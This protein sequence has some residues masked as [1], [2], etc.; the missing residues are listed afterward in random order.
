MPHLVRF[1]LFLLLSFPAT[2]SIAQVKYYQ[3]DASIKVIAY[4]QEQPLAWCGGFNT[5]QFASADLDHDGLND[6]VVF[7]KGL[8]VTTFINRGTAGKPDYVFAPEYAV[9]F[10]PIKN[11]LVLADYNCDG[12]ADLFQWGGYGFAVYKGYYNAYNQLCFTFVK[13]LYYFND[14]YAGGPVNAYCNPG[15]IPAIVDVDGDGDLDFISYDI[16]GGVMN[17]YKNMRE[18]LHLPCD[19]LHIALKDRCWGRVYQGFERAHRLAYSCDNSGLGRETKVTHSG[20]TPCLFDWDMDGDFDYLDGSVSFNEMTFLKNG[21]TEHGGVDSM[22][23]QDS[24]WQTGGKQINIPIWPAAY[25]I[26]V[27]QDGKKDLLIAPNAANSSEN[28]KC[29]WYYK[30]LSTPGNPS[31][32]FQSDSFLID[33]TIDLGSASYPM[34]FDYNRDSLPDLFV[35]SDGYRQSSGLLQSRISYYLNTGSPGYPKFTLQTND[36]LGMGSYA[37]RG[38]AP[39]VGDIDNDGKADLIIGHT[40]G[41]LSYFKNAATSNNLQPVWKL[42]QLQ[43]VDV[44]NDTINAGGNAAPFI[45]DIDKDGKPD[46][47]IG[48]SYG[49]IR[50]YQ[51]ISAVRGTISLKLINKRLGNT[52]V[53]PTQNL[54]NYCTPFIGRIDSTGVDYL[55]LG[56]NSGNIYRYTGFQGGDTTATYTLL[57][58]QY[59]YI[60]TTYLRINHPNTS[61][62]VYGNRRSALTVGD[63]GKDGGFEMIVGNVKGGLE[64]YKWKDPSVNPVLPPQPVK[65]VL[66]PNPAK[67]YINLNWTGLS[68]PDVLVNIFN[69]P[70]QQVYS[71]SFPSFNNPVNIS[72]ASLPSGVYVCVIR[73]GGNRFHIKFSVVK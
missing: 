21:R 25:N 8:G 70:G 20:N 17:L 35:G 2:Y 14:K 34:L 59:A 69:M 5:P 13:D 62:G 32:Q 52:R 54:G 27:D 57:D 11:Y 15:D 29:I 66:Y 30:N 41:T 50:Y 45:Y 26:D 28:Y 73:N 19:S 58:S 10:P 38:S 44:A 3:K 18:E 48:D 40:N 67:D 9:N 51:N 61:F 46:L 63:I 16:S 23:S 37:F 24:L 12:I 65:V 47:I 49:Y 60:D 33:K 42:E 56:S 6:L 4:G 43:L 53:D 64:L 72:V 55:L 31:W 71:G 22:V 7:E 1:F 68:E 36:F 39:A